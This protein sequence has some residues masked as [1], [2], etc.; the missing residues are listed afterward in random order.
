[1]T[2]EDACA[3]GIQQARSAEASRIA[4]LLQR[5]GVAATLIWV[6]RTLAIYHR[7]VLDRRH[8]AHIA[9]YRLEFVA[10]C[11][12]LRRWLAANGGYGN[13]ASSFPDSP[14]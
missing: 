4:F 10:S 11:L 6:R 5:D 8:F 2:N 1:M 13:R 9:E 12:E 7:A 14:P 3:D